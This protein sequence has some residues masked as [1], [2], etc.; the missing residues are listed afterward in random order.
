MSRDVIFK[1]QHFIRVSDAQVKQ[2]RSPA[3]LA[4]FVSQ[5]HGAGL[6]R[7]WHAVPYLI[8]GAVSGLKEPLAWFM[9]GGA[10]IG[11]NDA[12][13]IRYLSAARVARLAKALDEEPPDELGHTQYDEAAMDAAGVYPRR[14]V[15]DGE[16][17]DQ[18]GTIRET[19]GYVREYLD[20]CRRDRQGV[21]IF[22]KD[23]LAFTEDEDEADAPAPAPAS[24]E[25]AEESNGEVVL[26]GADGRQH[27]RADASAHPNVT[28]RMLRDADA[29]VGQLGYRHIGD[30]T[31]YDTDVLRTYMSE[32]RTTVALAY[33]SERGLGSWTF[34]SPLDGGALVVASDAFT[35]EIKK[36]K[37]FGQSLSRGTPAMLHQAVLD[38]R[39]R[40]ATKHG[41]PIILEPTLGS[42]AAVWDSFG[43]KSRIGPRR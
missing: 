35:Q 38:R 28:E 22:V 16:A 1:C 42:T 8:T 39:A 37:L 11:R 23:E 24:P 25:P 5:S 12:G 19:Y 29:T 10:V 30:L 41:A 3:A 18:L 15:R 17:F 6:G 2:L 13:P 7:Y 26:V 43:E 34:L 9:D 33:F 21:I 31:A 27:R 32:D 40:L 14:W 36:V 4:S 20:A